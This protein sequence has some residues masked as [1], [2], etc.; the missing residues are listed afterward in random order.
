MK[1]A[2][3]LIEMMIVVAV[4]A[5][6]TGILFRLMGVGED[7]EKRNITVARMQRLENCLSGYYAAFGS[8]PPV[9]LEGRSRNYRYE[10][11][12]GGIQQT[13]RNPQNGGRLN[14]T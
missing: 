11:N 8:Y 14:Y 3:T 9:E 1:R 4:I 13:S 7:A 2:F 5:I 10:V 12:P 6:L